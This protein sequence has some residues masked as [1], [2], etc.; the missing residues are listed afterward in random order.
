MAVVDVEEL[1]RQQGLKPNLQFFAKEYES[2]KNF[3]MGK[4][5]FDKFKV[6]DAYVKAKHLSTTT[7]K[8]R[9]FLGAT[10]KEAE[11]ILKDAIK[12]GEIRT[13]TKD[14][15]S[16]LGNIK[17]SIIIDAKKVVGTRGERFIK[18]VLSS[19][20]GMLTAYPQTI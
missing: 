17:Y 16:N 2:I 8:A 10:K 3:Q 12:N 20:G 1:A 5:I 7:G 6:E 9:Q 18:I 19:D 11:L 13:I 4:K 14:G 15:I